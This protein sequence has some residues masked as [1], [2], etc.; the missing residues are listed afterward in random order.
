MMIS[1]SGIGKEF[2]PFSFES[3]LVSVCSL[4]TTVMDK[5]STGSFD[6]SVTVSRTISPGRGF[7]GANTTLRF[8]ISG[9]SGLGTE[10]V[11]LVAETKLAEAPLPCCAT[12]ITVY[13]DTGEESYGSCK[14]ALVP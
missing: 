12:E 11:V 3:R 9:G 2:C 5:P 13:S 7:D 10:N 8:S 14:S 6:S 4:R 1:P